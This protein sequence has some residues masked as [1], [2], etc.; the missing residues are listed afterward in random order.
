[1]KVLCRHRLKNIKK[2]NNMKITGRKIMQIRHHW[3][4]EEVKGAA[5]QRG[6]R[7]RKIDRLK[8]IKMR[9]FLNR[10]VNRILDE[11]E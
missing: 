8:G 5:K 4:F 7:S 11:D 6:F 10:V 3:E 2:D 1:M 9:P